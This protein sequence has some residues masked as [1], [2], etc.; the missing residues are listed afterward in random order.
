VAIGALLAGVVQQSLANIIPERVGAGEASGIGL[1]FG[2]A[3]A[4]TA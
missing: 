2:G 1:N 4:A 3:A